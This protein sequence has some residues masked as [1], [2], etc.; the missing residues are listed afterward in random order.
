MLKSTS[1][2][3][4]GAAVSSASDFDQIK[5]YNLKHTASLGGIGDF[6]KCSG[7][8]LAMEALSTFLGRE[9]ITFKIVNL[10][11]DICVKFHLA[12]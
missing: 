2:A 6:G 11:I 7:C 8:T 1:L 5:Q 10:S 4:I 3:L 9:P 12:D